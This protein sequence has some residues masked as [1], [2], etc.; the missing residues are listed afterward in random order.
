MK[1]F[2]L[3]FSLIYCL[4]SSQVLDTEIYERTDRVDIFFILDKPFNSKIYKKYID[5]KINIEIE[6]VFID[7]KMQKTIDS[8]YISEVNLIPLKNKLQ[9][10]LNINKNAIVKIS[11]T[12]SGYG[13]RLRIYKPSTTK[14]SNN[15]EQR[16]SALISKQ[17]SPINTKYIIIMSLLFIFT[18]IIYILLKKKTSNKVS[19]F[20]NN[21]LKNKVNILFE[22]NI[23]GSNKVVLI[24]YLNYV[25]L[26]IL[27][28]NN[29]LLDKYSNNSS[30]SNED[31]ESIMQNKK[32]EISDYGDLEY[33]KQ[34]ALK[35]YSSRFH[36]NYKD[37][38]SQES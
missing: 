22:K 14:L 26:A 24:E 28:N 30:F 36:Q 16:L 8:P 32:Q 23:G 18:L 5:G 13:I 21:A 25:Y 17:T 7:T 34:K 9:V 2:L 15:N 35:E 3:L 19:I 10:L 37:K 31:F 38:L 33:N 4:S 6:N 11:K 1:I 20:T 29:V 27:G 12:K